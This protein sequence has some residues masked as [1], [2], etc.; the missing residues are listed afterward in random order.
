VLSP[1]SVERAKAA[2]GLHICHKTDNDNRRGL[3]D[4]NSLTGFLLVEL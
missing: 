2:R 1:D 4:G 3:N